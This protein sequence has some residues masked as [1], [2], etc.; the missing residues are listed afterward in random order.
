MD[1]QALL[2]AVTIV[3]LVGTLVVLGVTLWRRRGGD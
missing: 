2:Y 1:E 3:V